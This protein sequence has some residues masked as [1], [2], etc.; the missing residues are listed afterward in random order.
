VTPAAIAGD[1]I[2]PFFGVLVAV[3]PAVTKPTVAFGV[4]I[5]PERSGAPVIRTQRRAYAWRATT[6]AVVATALVLA[7]HGYDSRWLPRLILLLELAA[8]LG[9]Y[10]LARRRIADAKRGGRWFAGVRQTVVTDTNWR[11]DPPRF[12][13]RWLLPALAVI[14]ATIVTGVVRQVPA[15]GFAVVAGQAYVTALWGGLLVLAYRARP[16]I[17]AADPAASLA[18]YRRFL[19]ELATAM[20]VLVALVNVTLLLKG[21]QDWHV[22]RLSGA[23]SALTVVPFAAGLVLVGAIAVRAGRRGAR[24]GGPAPAGSGVAD[25]DDDRFWKAGLVYVN[26]DDPALVVTARFG[27]GWTLN[28]ANPR[29]WLL[30]A[31]IPV[32]IAAMAVIFR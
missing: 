4:R 13:V 2:V 3:G 7:L 27:T 1:I 17:T 31:A 18:R 24:L 15:S 26:T 25:R 9:C 12:P 22:Y 11:L 32:T 30:V 21:L 23:A 10:L 28:L 16:D 6:V 29:A 5:P 14:A 19:H 20:L 8:D